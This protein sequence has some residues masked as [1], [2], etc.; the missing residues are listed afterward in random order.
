VKLAQWRVMLEG[1][2]SAHP[3]DGQSWYLLGH[4]HLKQKSYAQAAS[5]F[6]SAHAVVGDDPS[7][8][9]YWLHARYLAAGGMLDDTSRDIAE[10]I[11]ARQPNQPQVLE[12]LAVDGFRGGRFREV[13]GLLDRALSEVQDPGQRMALRAG[14]E[15]ARAQLGDLV[16]GIDVS[17]EYGEVPPEGAV[18]FVIARPV[19][20]GM[21][22]TVVRRPLDEPPPHIRLDDAVSMN[23][24]VPLSSVDTVEVVVR[25]SLAGTVMAHPGDW[26]W[27][28]QPLALS[29]AQRV[30]NLTVSLSPP[31][32]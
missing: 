25:V 17:I 4:I 3:D 29:V 14:L 24:A 32:G 12:M 2:V 20:G 10:R 22:L 27:R 7:V 28:S 11:L 19:G 5:A 30:L 13:V 31:S 18:L 1:R 26:E 23:P 9:L 21:P 16:P 8:D 15:Q 6:G